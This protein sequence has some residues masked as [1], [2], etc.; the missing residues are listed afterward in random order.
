MKRFSLVLASIL[1]TCAFTQAQRIKVQGIAG[2]AATVAVS[3]ISSP[4]KFIRT[5][6]GSTVTIYAASTTNLASL[7]S[8]NLNPCTSKSNPFTSSATDATWFA[9]LLPGRYD[10]RF[11]GTGIVTPF[12]ISDV[13]AGGGSAWTQS[14]TSNPCAASDAFYQASDQHFYG[15]PTANNPSQFLL[16]NEQLSP[17]NI[18]PGVFNLLSYGAVCDG[19][20]A[21]DTALAAAL[22]AIGSNKATLLLPYTG[23][24]QCLL[25]LDATIPAN[26]TID[27]GQGSGWKGT[28][29]R[30]LTIAGPEIGKGTKQV[31]F[32]FLSGQGTISY[33]SNRVI[34]QIFAEHWGAV[35]DGTT[36]NA[37]PFQ[38]ALNA[39]NTT[40]AS[41]VIN[42]TLGIGVA[43]WTGISLT[44]GA[45]FSIIGNPGASI[46]IL[47]LPSQVL[48]GE[49]TFPVALRFI[50]SSY[51]QFRGFTVDGNA[52]ATNLLGF[53]TCTHMTV[54]GTRLTNTTGTAGAGVFSLVGQYNQ[55]S[56]NQLDALGMG[57]R[58]GHTNAGQSE[59]YFTV[60]NN[61]FVTIAN[62]AVVGV[63]NN[64]YIF[65]NNM[66]T[67]GAS[68][69]ALGAYNVS[70]EASHDVSI[71]SNIISNAAFQ[72]IQA[73][74]VGDLAIIN[75]S[76]VGNT[77]SNSAISG[78]YAVSS[79]KWTISANIIRDS[80]DTGVAVNSGN[81]SDII[82]NGNQISASGVSA[83]GIQ[84]TSQVGGKTITR[85]AVTN[86]IVSGGFTT[87]GII[88][89]NSAGTA[90]N[91]TVSGNVVSGAATG[92]FVTSGWTAVRVVNN[93][94]TGNTT[95]DIENDAAATDNVSFLHNIYTTS[96]GSVGA[97]QLAQV[98][99]AA[100]TISGNAIAPTSPIHHVTAGLIKNITVP[101]GFTGC[102]HLIPDNAYTYDASGNLVGTGTAVVGREMTAC[103]DSG[104]SKWYMSY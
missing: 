12:T 84:I 75:I 11:S 49:G 55:Y 81:C 67:M 33:T 23:T 82:I 57:L 43:G 91:A 30:T 39:A 80:T 70:G 48:S 92:L 31:Y 64:G 29:T 74:S 68:G 28:T 20:T 56:N 89:T 16:A 50:T 66:N 42:G 59:T 35:A 97:G 63:M 3:G 83:V 58:L 8:D 60:S 14:L 78:V 61:R 53:Q 54:D 85:I 17:A 96:S 26:V 65:G 34:T 94:L 102:I 32:N 98:I 103:Y 45:N 15:C 69:I 5:F 87:A 47:A 4:S 101:T 10:I 13:T 46:K 95:K 1:F 86:N 77:I 73:D 19:V 71:T 72:G 44:S 22:F 18:A 99:G 37:A 76:V 21:D 40:G 27:Y 51:I 88:L 104:T 36:N 79:K 93:I 38:I 2:Q 9:Y 90:N 25:S 100:L 6:P 7:C 24:G 41:L 52:L 62:D